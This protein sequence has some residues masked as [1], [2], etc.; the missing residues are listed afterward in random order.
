[1]RFPRIA[2]GPIMP[3]WRIFDINADGGC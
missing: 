3:L 1:M 2:G